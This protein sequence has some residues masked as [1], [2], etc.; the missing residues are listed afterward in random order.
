MLNQAMVGWMGGD[1]R[2]V[3]EKWGDDNTM[4]KNVNEGWARVGPEEEEDLN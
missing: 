2:G 1:G 4:T 3:W